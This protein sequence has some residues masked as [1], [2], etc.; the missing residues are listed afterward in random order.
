M[1]TL[2]IL[3]LAFNVIL[4][5]PIKASAKTF[6]TLNNNDIIYD[7]DVLD[8]DEDIF[9]YNYRGVLTS[10]LSWTLVRV[11]ITA[12]RIEVVAK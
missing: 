7:G 3:I 12:S 8:L 6:S 4:C 5:K 9:F 2:S 1:V 11:N 10:K